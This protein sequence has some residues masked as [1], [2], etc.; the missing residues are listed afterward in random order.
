[1]NHH[2]SEQVKI[3]QNVVFCST[4]WPLWWAKKKFGKWHHD[5]QVV[6]KIRTT[7]FCFCLKRA[8]TCSFSSIFS[9][10]IMAKKVHQV[11]RV[12][13]RHLFQGIWMFPY[14]LISRFSL[15]YRN[16]NFWTIAYN[17]LGFGYELWCG[18]SYFAFILP[19]KIISSFRT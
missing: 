9:N 1:M 19:L 5:Q 4:T 14:F 7:F 13:V 16:N 2:K 10:T 8:P 15:D 3:H 12:K 6:T 17:Q 18:S 11:F